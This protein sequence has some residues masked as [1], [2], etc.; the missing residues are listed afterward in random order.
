MLEYCV[1]RDTEEIA[2]CPTEFNIKTSAELTAALKR[3]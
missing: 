2:S 3:F 1:A